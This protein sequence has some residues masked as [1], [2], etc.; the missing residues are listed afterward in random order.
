MTRIFGLLLAVLAIG[1]C[2]VGPDYERPEL[3]LPEQWPEALAAHMGPD[4]DDIAFWWELYE[5]PVLTRL[6][7]EA[8]ANNLD[9]AQAAARIVQARAVLGFQTAELFPVIGA[10][11]SYDQEKSEG[12]LDTEYVFAGVLSYEVDLWGRLRRAR[13]AARARLFATAYTRNAVRLAVITDVVTTYF[14]YRAIREQIEITEAT[15]VAFKEALELER[16][17]RDAGATTDLTV[18]QAKAELEASR[19]VLP[20]LRSAAARARR[21]LAVLVG[22]SRATLQGLDQL[23]E[24]ELLKT[25]PASLE[26]LPRAVPSDLLLRRPDIRAAEAFLIAANADIGSARALW[27][28]S[29]VIGGRYGTQAS[30]S[31]NLFTAAGTLW[32]IVANAMLPIIDFGRR[33][34]LVNQTQAAREIAEIQYRAVIQNAFREV[35]NAWTLLQAAEVRLAARKR[36]IKARV[37]VLR[38]AE[39]RYIGEFSSYL[40]VLDA[41]RSLFNARL[42]F[43][44]A[45]RDRLVAAAT[46]FRTLG[47][48]WQM[49]VTPASAA[50][51]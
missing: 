51:E 18:L 25:L 10:Q 38:L 15:Q 8:L 29:L 50:G 45:A 40:Q 27:F 39:R 12:K 37:E 42:S 17:R 34:A 49:D 41:R 31:T 1:G 21:A 6:I 43:I 28:P 33:R 44:D 23:G 36:E 47:G 30:M 22:D 13:E 16:D 32:Q 9:L 7:E 26:R 48:G 11:A 2:T 19:A 24:Q 46:L 20:I 35:G 5:D 4:Y 3:L 14:S